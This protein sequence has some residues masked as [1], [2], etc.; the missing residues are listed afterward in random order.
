MRNNHH[1]KYRDS[2]SRGPP[3]DYHEVRGHLRLGTV[4]IT[5]PTLLQKV[6][7][8]QIVTLDEDVVLRRAVYDAILTISDSSGVHNASQLHYLF[9]NLFRGVCLRQTP[10][11]FE[12]TGTCTLPQRYRHFLRDGDPS[13]VR[14]P[15]FVQVQGLLN[16]FVNTFAI[17]IT[18]ENSLAITTYNNN[19][20]DLRP[21]RRML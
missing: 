19:R 10:E 15:I 4:Q 9:W 6:R 18:I 11:C 8:G 14:S 1:W 13:A 2:E 16:R 21:I 7:E 17:R 5:D 3:V 12:V 20:T